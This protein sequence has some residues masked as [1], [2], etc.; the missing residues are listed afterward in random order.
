MF[1]RARFAAHIHIMARAENTEYYI[2]FKEENGDVCVV[3]AHTPEHGG[4]MT[5]NMDGDLFCATLGEQAILV[6]TCISGGDYQATFALEFYVPNGIEKIDKYS[7]EESLFMFKFHDPPI[8]LYPRL[9]Y[10]TRS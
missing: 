9:S 8:L 10:L 2:T 1:N 3:L 4:R 7:L 6:S 5:P